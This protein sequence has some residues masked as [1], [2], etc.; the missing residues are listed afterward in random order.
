[1]V[2]KK[3]FGGT[4]PFSA[5]SVVWVPYKGIQWPA[6]ISRLYASQKKVT[7]K[8]LPIDDNAG[9]FN[10][11]VSKIRPFLLKDQLPCGGDDKLKA[12]FKAAIEEVTKQHTQKGTSNHDVNVETGE[13]ELN[14]DAFR[15]R[16]CKVDEKLEI[17]K[18]IPKDFDV[19]DIVLV[20]WFGYAEWPA[21]V[22]AVRK[23]TLACHFFPLETGRPGWCR[24]SACQDFSVDQKTFT[25]M[26]KRE[27]TRERQLALEEAWEL[28]TNT[29]KEE[30]RES[31]L[32]SCKTS[33]VKFPKRSSYFAISEQKDQLEKLDAVTDLS[34]GDTE[35]FETVANSSNS[36]NT[37]DDGG[38]LSDEKKLLFSERISDDIKLKEA[39]PAAKR[40]KINE[41]EDENLC[42][43]NLVNVF[44]ETNSLSVTHFDFAMEKFMRDYS[45]SY[46]LRKK[47]NISKTVRFT[48]LL[49]ECLS[50]KKGCDEKMTLRNQLRKSSSDYASVDEVVKEKV[51]ELVARISDGFVSDEVSQKRERQWLL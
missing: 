26:R 35:I 30:R 32:Q 37:I 33:K 18:N 8:F 41:Y 45:D 11:P 46:K 51:A 38:I 19:G 23:H 17:K 44:N 12:A 43:N 39:E 7:Y 13:A 42:I 40:K 5:G 50:G 15:R 31:Y 47:M 21:I 49:D 9:V 1:M 3:S 16:F 29:T 28:M 6:M 36:S 20:N 25:A 34:S 4:G 24:K 27:A 22:L 14:S 2:K 48:Q 10:A